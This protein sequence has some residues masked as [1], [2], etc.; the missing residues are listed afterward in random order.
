MVA[1]CRTVAEVAEL[2]DL[3]SLVPVQRTSRHVRARAGHPPRGRTTVSVTPKAATHI[4][5]PVLP[6]APAR[7]KTGKSGMAVVMMSPWFSK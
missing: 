1:D 6:I 4:P 5:Q 2:V 3:A 7:S